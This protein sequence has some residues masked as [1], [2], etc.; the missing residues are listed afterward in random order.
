MIKYLLCCLLLVYPANAAVDSVGISTANECET[1]WAVIVTQ[2]AV[3]AWVTPNTANLQVDSGRFGIG[4][5]YASPD[6]ALIV[7]YNNS[8]AEPSTLLANSDS[9]FANV[10]HD[11]DMLSV[12]QFNQ[13]SLPQNDTVWI[14]LYMVGY[15]GN[16]YGW[17]GNVL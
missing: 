11:C 12:V 6:T 3:A 1:G 7:I 10:H 2:I 8:S 16:I 15:N 5:N 9:A 4:D 13:E 14:G 17:S